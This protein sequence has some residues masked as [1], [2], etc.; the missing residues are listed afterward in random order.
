MINLKK[1][2]TKILSLIKAVSVDYI[3]DEGK[4]GN[5]YYRKWNSGRCEQWLHENPG[6]YTVSTQRGNMYSGAD[7]TRTFPVAFTNIHTFHGSVELQ[8]TNYVTLLQITGFS[9]TNLTFRIV[10]GSSVSANTNY[11]LQIYAQ[12]TWK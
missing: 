7:I 11:W 4:S 1:L 5:W 9:N 10:A 2:L 12:G 6:S 8:T 3:V